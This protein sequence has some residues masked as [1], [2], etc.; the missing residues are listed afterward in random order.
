MSA[1]DVSTEGSQQ[2]EF[3]GH[4]VGLW[5]CFGTEM[6][7][8]FSYYGMRAIL[9]L[10]L[11]KYHMFSSIKANMV[12]GAYM[13]MVYMTPILGGYLADRYLGSRKAVVYGGILLVL[14]HIMM[15]FHGAPAILDADGVTVIRD[16]AAISFFFFAMALI[17]GGMGFLKANISTIVGALYGPNDPRRDGGF[18]IFYMGIN[19]GSFL[20]TIIV[21]GVGE[22]YGWNYGFALAGICMLLGLTVFLKWQHLLEGRAD[23]PNP[24]ELKNKTLIG[25]NIEHTIYL[26]GLV[27]VGLC[28]LLLQRQE[29]IGNMLLICGA[30]MLIIVGVYSV[31]ECTAEERHR[32]WVAMFLITMQPIFW[33]LF[34]QQAGS[35]TLLADQQFDLHFLGMDIYASQVQTLNPFFIV[36]LAPVMAWLW[37]ALA[38]KG[39]EP[40]TPL[41]F[42]IAM[43][44]IGGGYM[45]F[46]WGLVVDEGSAK[47]FLWFVLIYLALTLGELCLS[48]IGLS[49]VTKLSV[50]KIVGM[51]MGVWFL[52]MAFGNYMSGVIGGLAGN[53]GHGADAALLDMDKTVDLFNTVGLL[54]IGVGI[55]ILILTPWLRKGMHGVH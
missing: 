13:G 49:M 22:K 11:V 47:S 32:L 5:V 9:V 6:W 18:S 25:L 15:G 53:T 34:E 44:L 41:K 33:A 39:W 10:Y 54:G 45:I 1:V 8:R 14:G 48:P 7:E 50:Q 27:L 2:R 37:L 20:A 29:L 12:L 40:S 55:F 42:S 16:D 24:E 35:L 36:T 23:P 4:P 21:G 26:G 30:V 17:V 28:F 31:R 19:I 52:G 3:L 46:A 38:K 43:I 51:M